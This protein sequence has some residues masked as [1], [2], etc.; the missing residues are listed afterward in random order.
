VAFHSP[1][2]FR[3]YPLKVR[4]HHGINLFRLYTDVLVVNVS[5]EN[6]YVVECIIM[7]VLVCILN[8]YAIVAGHVH[9]NAQ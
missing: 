3:V 8:L 2:T 6:K 9:E 4:F 1:M 7:D 5:I